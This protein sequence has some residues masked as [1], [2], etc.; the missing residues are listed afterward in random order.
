[1]AKLTDERKKYISESI[2][3]VMSKEL[4]LSDTRARKL[5]KML[6]VTERTAQKYIKDYKESHK[7]VA[8]QLPL[9]AEVYTKLATNEAQQSLNAIRIKLAI[10]IPELIAIN[11]LLI[12]MGDIGVTNE[13]NV[14]GKKKAGFV[15]RRVRAS[16]R[17]L[18]FSGQSYG[19]SK[20][21]DTSNTKDL[22]SYSTGV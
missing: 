13:P 20:D 12:S 8:E 21:P 4:S 22:P 9:F 3:S 5:G 2:T 15:S 14:E 19:V 17:N 16:S 7:D 6:G 10:I 18:S 11:D 1:M